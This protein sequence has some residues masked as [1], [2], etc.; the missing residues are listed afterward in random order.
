[1]WHACGTERCLHCFN[2]QDVSVDER[3]TLR[4]TLG[5]WRSMGRT[6]FGWVRIR[7]SGGLL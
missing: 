3:I 2:G 7:S 6:G 4:W 5:I 1:M